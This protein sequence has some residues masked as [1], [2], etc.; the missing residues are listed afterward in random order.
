MITQGADG[1]S[2]GVHTQGIM[3]G[4]DFL[5]YIPLHLTAFE[6]QGNCLQDWIESWFG[7]LGEYHLLHPVDWY[8]FAHIK[9][10]CVWNPAPA[11][12][13]AALEQLAK[14]PHKRPHH[15][16]LV[17]IPRVMTALWRKMLGK[18]CDLI[19]TVP[20]GMDVWS[21]SQHEPLIVGLFLPLSKH[22]PWKLRGT[23]MLERVE[24][25][26]RELP[27]SNPRWGGDLLCKL[28]KQSRELETL[29]E[30][31]VRPL[32]HSTG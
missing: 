24:R 22:R 19:F 17:L 1:L 30:S 4:D 26:L 16:H 18:I 28:L 3:R 31:V 29:Q 13:E 21:Y 15:M 2:R 20:V 32:L 10:R 5:E 25:L 8:H 14:L 7:S 9:E 23:P 11:A 6:R 12:A 27:L